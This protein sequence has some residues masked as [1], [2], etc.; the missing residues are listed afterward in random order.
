MTNCLTPSPDLTHGFQETNR[1]LR[2]WLD[3]LAP[4]ND[5]NARPR[6]ATPQQMSGLLSEL[7]QAG[8]TLRSLPENKDAELQKEL[9][10][11]RGLVE[12]LRD[13]MPAIHEGLLRERARLEGERNRLVSAS[14]WAE[15]SRQTL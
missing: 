15:A 12:R 10:D 13:L 9:N 11:Y 7:M 6:P 14:Q 4:S 3:S 2:F 1:R 8:S 5:P